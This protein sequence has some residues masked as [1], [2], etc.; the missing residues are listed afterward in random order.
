MRRYDVE[1]NAPFTR[2]IS[3]HQNSSIHTFTNAHHAYGKRMFGWKEVVMLGAY[4]A[5]GDEAG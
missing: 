3:T 5:W 2:N 1:G 4:E